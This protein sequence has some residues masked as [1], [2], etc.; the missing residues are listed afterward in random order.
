MKL[1]IQMW[2]VNDICME[3]G[4][5][6]ALKLIKEMGYEGFEFA[7]GDKANL[8]E[9]CGANVKEV[10]RALK[11]YEVEAIGSHLPMEILL[12]NP[13]SVLK[14]CVELELPYAAIGPAFWGD[15][16]PHREQK[17][18]YS[19]IKKL[20][21]IFKRNGIKLQVHC[22]AFGYLKD[23]RGR[24]VVEGMLE[25]AGLE[26][27]QPEFDTAWM[28]C[29]GVNPIEYLHKYANY[30][31]VLHLKDFH[32]LEEDYKYLMVRHNTIFERNHKEGCAIGDNGIQDVKGIIEAA[33][34]C[35]TK[36]LVVELWNE[37]NSIQN[38]EL[39]LGNIL[40]YM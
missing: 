18:I 9:C 12:H 22:S 25:E 10:V 37:K 17:E 26:L 5:P 24:Y 23:Y 19:K 6:Y 11:E 29:G 2:S 40:K 28:V 27:L 34:K 35:C 16:T 8:K 4:I 33:K 7:L 38:A 32:P 21:E 39:S 20:G 13:E 31:D 30:T 15:R 1:G 36:W 3:Q 14:E